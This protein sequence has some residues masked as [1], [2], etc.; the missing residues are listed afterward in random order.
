MP[1]RIREC[2]IYLPLDYNDGNP[3]AESYF[4]TLQRQLFSRFGGVSFTQHEFPLRGIWKAEDRV[5]QDRVVIYSVI[6]F[7]AQTDFEAIRYLHGLKL[8][9]KKKLDQLEILITLQE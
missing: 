1:R 6:D 7:S 3:I 2:H 5:Y 4:V 9:L 8:R